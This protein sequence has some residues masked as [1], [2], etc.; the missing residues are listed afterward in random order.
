MD[1]YHI[2][3]TLIFLGF[4]TLEIFV[5]RFFNREERPQRCDHRNRFRIVNST[6]HRAAGFVSHPTALELKSDFEE[7]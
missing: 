3:I 6:I 7:A 1:D 4:A 2:H 5:G